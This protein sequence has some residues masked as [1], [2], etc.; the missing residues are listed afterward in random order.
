MDLTG[1]TRLAGL[2]LAVVA[3]LAVATT[4]LAVN[5][6]FTYATNST[7]A[8]GNLAVAFQEA[9][10]GAGMTI[11]YKTTADVTATWGCYNKS[12]KVPTAT[13]KRTST[14]VASNIAVLTAAKNGNITGKLVT[15]LPPVAPVDFRCPSGQTLKLVSAAWTNI[16]LRDLTTPISV[17]VPYL[18]G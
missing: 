14:G 4:A 6:H 16:V 1:R 17:N 12:G 11:S 5:V 7:D 13:N 18:A 9:G 15:Q 3:S 8:A 2:T 10:L